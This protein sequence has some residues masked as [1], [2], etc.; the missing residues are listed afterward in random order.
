MFR[1]WGKFVYRRRRWVA[2]AAAAIALASLLLAR[3]VS[4]VLTTGGWYAPGS[5][6]EQVAATL[7]R[8]FGQGRS[9]L[10]VLFEAPGRTDAAS[11]AFQAEVA[12]GVSRLAADSRVESVVGFAQTGSPRFISDTGDATWVLVNLNLDQDGALDALP[13]LKAELD[14]PAGMTAQVT[15]E[16]PMSLAVSDQSERDLARAESISLPI[17]LLILLLVFGSLVAAGLPLLVAVLAIPTALAEVYLVGGQMTMSVFVTSVVTM[18]GLALAIDYSLFMVSRFREELDGGASVADSVERTVATSGKAVVFSGSVVVLG[19]SGLLLFS[20]PTLSS[21][22]VGGVL[23]A[24]SSVFYALTF[25]PAVLGML[26]PRVSWL[27]PR[28]PRGVRA[29]VRPAAGT[30]SAASMSSA[31]SPAAPDSGWWHRI[32]GAVMRRP[33]AVLAPVLAVLL[34]LGVPFLGVRSGVP[35]VQD[36]PA[37]SEAR[38][39]WEAIETRFPAGESQPIE[40]LVSVEGDPASPANAAALARYAADLRSLAGVSRVD[41]PFSLTDASGQP[42]PIEAVA[43]AVSAPAEARPETLNS[44]LA[45]FVRGS[46]VRM[47]VITPLTGTP[48]ARDLVERIRA[49]EPQGSGAGALNVAVG[50]VDA[51]SVDFLTALNDQLPAAMI[52]I[53][54]VMAV[55]LLLQ[56]GSIVLSIKAVFMTLL[57]LT[58]SFGALVWIFQDGNL[59]GLLGFEVLGYTIVIVPIL[60]FAV[61][62]GLSMDYEVLLLSRIQESY[63]R[64]GNNTLAVADGLARSGRVITGAALIMVVVFAAFGLAEGMVIKSLGVGLAIAVLVDATV[65]RVLVVPATMRL[66]GRWNWWAPPHIAG[67]TGRLGFGDSELEPGRG[68][69]PAADPAG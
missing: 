16:A 43:A 56:F 69:V 39:T 24:L 57:S 41:G 17:A 15:G 47:P 18:L 53:L 67:L 46:T 42:L 9:S 61:V 49:M 25:L 14:A 4:S 6:S 11:P 3:D 52:C 38:T 54:V 26:G 1:R 19:L 31:T 35:G 21:M 58:A 40:V 12:A 10:V 64:S 13:A 51:A 65:I 60:T 33:L 2:A 28:L 30:G 55:M 37:G 32:S 50:G 36:L 22:G 29:G 63:R 34:L 68:R 5:E 48:S 8:D 27:Q 66:L 23:I 45:A 44:C 62:F 20:P 59:A 7:E